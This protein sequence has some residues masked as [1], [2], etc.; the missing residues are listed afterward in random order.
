MVQIEVQDTVGTKQGIVVNRRCLT[1]IM[2]DVL[3]ASISTLFL[4]YS[5]AKN[6]ISPLVHQLSSLKCFLVELA[7]GPW[8]IE[9]E[10]AQCD[11]QQQ[12]INTHPA[13]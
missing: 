10:V 6:S 8:K 1:T 12:A 11:K 13:F 2:Q 4:F 3:I 9:F 7:S 5:K